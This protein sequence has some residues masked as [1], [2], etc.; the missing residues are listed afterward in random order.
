MAYITLRINPDN[1]R[2]AIHHPVGHYMEDYQT[3]D[4]EAVCVGLLG[5]NPEGF[6]NTRDY[7]DLRDALDMLTVEAAK[8]AAIL[9]KLEEQSHE[10]QA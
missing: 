4:G 10:Q 3:E 5:D 2:L 9:K 6:A 7:D 1:F 8:T